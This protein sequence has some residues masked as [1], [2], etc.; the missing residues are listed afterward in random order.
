MTTLWQ[1]VRY[2]SRMFLKAPGFAVMVLGILA[3]GM[4]GSMMIFSIYN[5]MNLR[6]FP[7]PDQERLADLDERAPE[8]NLEY[9]GMAYRDFH[10]WRRLNQ[11]FDCMT[12]WEHMGWNLSLD[13]RTERVDGVRVTHDYFD[14][15]QIR[16][17]LGRRFV[18]ED[19]RPGAARVAILSANLWQQMYGEAADVIGRSL[20][21]D[22][23]PHTI[24][25]VLPRDTAFPVRT[26]LWVP[27]ALDPASPGGWYLRGIG[28]LKAGVGLAGAQADLEHVH[29]GM[30]DE[31]PVNKS[32]I[33]RL[34]P[35]RV[36]FMGESRH[37]TS[38][39]LAAAG[40]VLLLACCNIAGMMLARG[41]TRSKELAVRLALGAPRSRIVRQ[42]LTE[43]LVLCIPGA[44]LGA[45][46]SRVGLGFLL[47]SVSEHLAPWM[48]FALDGRVIA[49]CAGVVGLATILSGIIPAIH[50]A[51][52]GNADTTLRA[53]ASRSTVSLPGRRSLSGIVAGEIALAMTL[54]VGAVLLL[55]A[56]WKVCRVEPGFRT[57]GI[58]TY[59]ISL[60]LD[61]YK[62]HSSR[63]AFFESHLERIRAL[64][65]V[66]RASFS[67]LSPLAGHSGNFLDVEGV[68]RAP[69]EINPVVLTQIVTTDYFETLGIELL[70][71]RP[72]SAED[73]VPDA[74]RTA[75]VS[76]MFAKRFA[77]NEAALGKR[78]AFQGSDKWMR[79]IAVAKDVRHYGLDQ[80]IRPAVYLPASDPRSSMAATVR[81]TG[82]PL[83]LVPAVREIVRSAD[84]ML[85]VHDVQTLCDRV[86]DSLW[87]RRTYSWLIGV[88]AAVAAIMAVGGVY[89]MMSYSVSRRIRETGIRLALGAG[90]GDIIRHLLAQGGRVI[91]VG[92]AAGLVGA[93]VMGRLLSRLL[94]GVSMVDLRAMLGVIA[95]LL[96]VTLLACYVPARR[97]AKI[98]PM[99]ALRCE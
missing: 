82:D 47:R 89:G 29:R 80:A 27:L 96:F 10:D 79:V 41:M 52:G 11:T 66:Q 50:A 17:V 28:K 31:R 75:I 33:P 65:P 58:L 38:L 42:V 73:C 15:L 37:V 99:V 25:G 8:W 24:V 22:G 35:L 14:V 68:T 95:L 7:V 74:E 23:E 32:T 72:F 83:A 71:G 57:Q 70:V 91:G 69:G 2:A 16:P 34:T 30:I 86:H 59:R 1:D 84:P 87:I 55:Q 40:M 36:R 45:L 94:F 5:E 6:P 60:P 93:M 46:L 53:T 63:Q 19:D 98:D 76:E 20:R 21:L 78:I 88:F 9:T 77:S 97:A 56:F 43:T 61:Q 48:T 92:L 49:F 51:S 39:L 4:G 67:D 12:V 18:E 62:D 3:V 64:P 26:D 44:L 85:S 13:G 81:T 54:S 90:T